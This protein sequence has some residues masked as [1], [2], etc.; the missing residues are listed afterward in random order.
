MVLICVNLSFRENVL[1]RWVKN[2][3]AKVTSKY[4]GQVCYKSMFTQ[5]CLHTKGLRYHDP[6]SG[7]TRRPSNTSLSSRLW[8]REK[9]D[10]KVSNLSPHVH[11]TKLGKLIESHQS[12]AVWELINSSRLNMAIPVIFALCMQTVA[13]CKA[14]G[15]TQPLGS[16][17]KAA[18]ACIDRFSWFRVSLGDKTVTHWYTFA[19]FI[20]HSL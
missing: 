9:K 4:R 18:R 14:S 2:S 3:D 17:V 10:S 6:K 5:A 7:L 1:N 16:P 12:G 19:A 13:N 11:N 8:S 20:S 15:C